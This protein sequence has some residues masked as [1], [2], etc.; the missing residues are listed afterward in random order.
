[1]MFDGGGMG[2][3][4]S[5]L[6]SG[7][8][9]PKINW[10]EVEF[11]RVIFL[12]RGYLFILVGILFLA[13]LASLIG[14][15]PPLVLMKIIDVVIPKQD[16]ELLT[17]FVVVLVSLPVLGGLLGVAQNHLNN[18]VAEGV[19]RD[20]R[21]RL[22]VRLQQQSMAF[23]T[24]SRSGEIVQRLIGDVQTVQDV[25]TR[26]V[27][28]GITQSVIVLSTLA[29]LFYLDWQ[30]ALISIL[31]IPLF[32]FPIRYVS[33]RR[34]QLRAQVQEARADLSARISEMFGVSGA[35]QTKLFNQEQA[36]RI[37]FAE[38]N[39]R[40]MDLELRLQ[41]I[42]RWFLM[43][44]SI[45]G[46]VGT[47]LVYYYGGWRIFQ[48][49]MTL[50]EI[51]A[52][53]A[54]LV[55]L[56][57]PLSQLLNLHVE[58]VTALAV[59][60]R[61]F[62]Y[63]DLPVTIKNEENAIEIPDDILGNVAFRDVSFGYHDKQLILRNVSFEVRAGQVIAIVGPSGAG[64]STLLS[65]VPRLFD[66]QHGEITLDGHPFRS[67]KLESLRNVMA[68]VTQE[69]FLWHT[70]IRENLTFA[71]PD[72]D[73]S[74]LLAA[75]KLAN[76]DSLILRLPQGLDTV[77]GERGHRLSGGERQRLAIARAILAN[78]RI[79]L[80]DEATAHLDAESER[81]VQ[82][83]L[84]HLIQS[85]TTLVV[86]HRLSTILSADYILVLD[87][88]EIVERGTHQQLLDKNGLY[89]RIYQTQM[90]AS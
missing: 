29:I 63:L 17:W 50:G 67:L 5:R 28:S 41:L 59:F 73:D 19:M 56:Y 24:S 74:Q 2:H 71:C 23:F 64:K 25:L 87:Q 78:P 76:I 39:Q 75:C 4:F 30:L 3:P 85:R 9:P 79:L 70:T 42:G 89:A 26:L 1:M 88:G 54:C 47:A 36:Q 72:A 11:A 51:I 6:D 82:A 83:A 34:K 32:I 21:D 16:M 20:L 8:K 55:R 65:L 69:T 44:V 33:R 90:F 66:P 7:G 57:Q 81:A 40:V 12:F 38:V 14:L 86:A 62:E 53:A 46:P 10:R 18:K 52:F 27:V 68:T 48:E 77:V 84:H 43:M 31:T 13:T 49:T 58:V 22:F 61:I 37:K 35:L 15:V 60:K 45:L 80:L